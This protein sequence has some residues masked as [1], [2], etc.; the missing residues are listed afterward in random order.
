MNIILIGSGNVA[1]QLGIAFHEKGFR[2]AQVYNPHP[3]SAERLGNR[4]DAEPVTYLENIDRQADLYIFAVKDAVLPELL[5]QFPATGG[6][7]VHTSGSLSMRVF[8][9][10]RNDRYGV[11]Y[12][13]QTFTRDRK[14]SFDHLPLFIEARYR[15]DE[16]RLE[17]WANALSNTVFHLPSDKRKH[18]HLAAVF[19][20]NF[21]N[22]LYKLAA[23][24]LEQQDLPWEAVLPLIEETAAKV[25][26]MH[27]R[28]A[29][30][31]P[32]V[33]NDRN[34][35]DKHLEMLHSYP[36]I[37]EMYRLISHNIGNTSGQITQ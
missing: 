11:L 8:E 30:T 10:S 4:L 5:K 32:A 17:Q 35:M 13:L 24:I 28:E 14:M 9:G 2:T 6:L 34:T 1:T 19:A 21:T 36:E 16:Q 15:E 22:H 23:Q 25:R 29:Q 27:P 7:W 3:A 18:L 37:Q 33:R 12:P 31:G 26:D 20:C